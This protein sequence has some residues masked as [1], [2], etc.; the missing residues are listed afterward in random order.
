MKPIKLTLTAFG[1]FQGTEVVDFESLGESPLFLI[2]GPTGSGKT[3]ILDGICFA[4]YGKT[5]GNERDASQMRCHLSA[6][7]TLTEITFVF[8]LAGKRYQIR[9]SPEQ[10][11][12]KARGDGFTTK[13][14]EAELLCLN[15]VTQE[16]E[17]VLV[18][19]KV[20]EANTQIESLLGLSVDQFRQVMV[21]PQGKFRELLTAD[22][23]SRERIFSQL[24]QTHIFQRIEQ[25][26]K[27]KSADIRARV[28][29]ARSSLNEV[30]G[31]LELTNTDELVSA[32]GV[33]EV[34]LFQKELRFKA[35]RKTSDDLRKTI[36]EAYKLND[37]YQKRSVMLSKQE[38]LHQQS[39]SIEKNKELVRSLSQVIEFESEYLLLEEVSQQKNQ[40]NEAKL[41]SD[42]ALKSTR[43]ARQLIE[44]KLS[45]R[46]LLESSLKD[47]EQRVYQLEA[48]LPLKHQ[49][50]QY[51]EQ[52][53]KLKI[54]A[55][56]QATHQTELNKAL[57]RFDDETS[58]LKKTYD[59][60]ALVL[61]ALEKQI[62]HLPILEKIADLLNR[63]F[64]K[65]NKINEIKSFLA[66]KKQEGV[67][68]KADYEK[69]EVA[70]KEKEIAW[71]L[72]QAAE[73]A[74]TLQK[75]TPCPVCGSYD[76]P[77][78]AHSADQ[79]PTKEEL[80]QQQLLV[81]TLG[82]QL[83]E[84]RSAYASSKAR[85]DEETGEYSDL[86]E[87]LTQLGFEGSI[88]TESLS[89]ISRQV[90][91][92][93]R[94]SSEYD[95]SKTA[96]EQLAQ[97][98]QQRPEDKAKLV[99]SISDAQLAESKLQEQLISVEQNIA[100]SI[101]QLEAAG[102]TEK[103]LSHLLSSSKDQKE[104]IHT[105]LQNLNKEDQSSQSALN[106]VLARNELYTQQL[107]EKADHYDQLYQTF[108]VGI[109]S[110]KINDIDRY[111]QQ[112]SQ[113]D[114]AKQAQLL[115]DQYHQEQQ[116][117]AA[118]LS[119]IEELIGGQELPDTAPLEV[120]LEAIS[121]RLQSAETDWL[122]ARDH[123]AYVSRL[124]SRLTNQTNTLKQLEDEYKVVGTLSDIANGQ[125]AHKISLQRFV[126]SALLDDVLMEASH[127]L[128]QMTNTRYRLL[129]KEDRAKGNKASGLELEVEDAFTG[130]VRAVE[131]LSGG[132]GF[133][134]ALS[135][136]LGL[137][138]VVQA[139]SGG[140]RLDVLF[141]DEGFGSLDAE[142]LDL[143]IATLLDLRSKG[144][145][146]GVISHVAELKEQ[147]SLKVNL[148]TDQTGSHIKQAVHH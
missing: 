37:L 94:Q 38:A 29:A 77:L 66:A 111:R 127:R 16:V 62:A 32:L 73:L 86:I 142:A 76:H 9:R 108:L 80:K 39:E 105:E 98:L 53:H 137:S 68:I 5:T 90:A 48:L 23:A 20:S 114:A 60:R 26:L 19:S 10:Q 110:I 99:S 97:A 71:H 51:R 100:T 50:E 134:A 22:S 117:L 40:L 126:L 2:N 107:R 130:R 1:P 57:S 4:L 30:L 89:Q 75:D 128:Y 147:I 109:K 13:A 41:T 78:P 55:Q 82:N 25:N 132:E 24:F 44:E 28:S 70:L 64:V 118:S 47:V 91:D 45:G 67:A 7:D 35:L 131:T 106:D 42:R 81:N 103:S 49:L 122:A 136:A 74:K 52:A 146:I 79:I 121:Q 18:S 63:A 129:R 58:A 140:V 92:L 124:Q 88:N 46:A 133:M 85:L 61:Q 84:M 56:Q 115:I 8:E 95:Q 101:E 141:I 14:P 43:A 143:A 17:Q 138:D 112:L 36:D 102:A 119:S 59:E 144:R 135:L 33:A 11:K 96:L 145:M 148:V 139:Y 113:K 116:Q 104:K 27:E 31:Q 15:P 72:G 125:N 3:S 120:S 21:L 12:P 83:V 93:K 54:D 34:D 6:A 69:A 123:Q 87:A 65:S